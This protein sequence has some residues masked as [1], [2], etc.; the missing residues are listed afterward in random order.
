MRCWLALIEDTA[1]VN[2]HHLKSLPVINGTYSRRI[3]IHHRLA[4]QVLEDEQM[5]KV[6]WGHHEWWLSLVFIGCCC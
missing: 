1:T 4:Y 3:T 2:L 6:R 5:V